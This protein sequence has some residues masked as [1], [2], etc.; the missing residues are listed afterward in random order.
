MR[1]RM[2]ARWGSL[3]FA[4]AALVACEDEGSPLQQ[5]MTQPPAPTVSYANALQPVFDANCVG[6]HGATPNGGLDL[7]A[8]TSR[9]N[10]VGILSP[11]YG[12][13]RVVRFQPESSVLYD[14]VS[15]GGTYGSRMPLG[16][17]ALAPAVVES[18]RVWI[19]EGA[20]DN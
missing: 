5:E 14:K 2:A 12:V 4:L 7:R 13:A 8:P 18:I 16:L 1:W 17:P 9:A 6:C 3:C 20:L 15:G 10:L 19:A 11:T